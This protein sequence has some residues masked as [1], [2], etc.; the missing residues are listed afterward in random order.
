MTETTTIDPNAQAVLDALGEGWSFG[1]PGESEQVAFTNGDI[2]V[3]V[4]AEHL[5]PENASDIAATIAHAAADP[6]S[7]DEADDEEH[8]EEE[9]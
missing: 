2:T 6:D 1:E 5:T 7:I 4:G 3:G 8:E 9:E